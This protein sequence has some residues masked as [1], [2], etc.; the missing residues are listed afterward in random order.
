VNR[1]RPFV[2]AVV[3]LCAASCGSGQYGYS[4]TYE[5][6]EAEEAALAGAEEYDPVMAKRQP[7]VWRTKTV[8]L[9]GIVSKREEKGT[10]KAYLTLSVRTLEARNAC[11]TSV[12]DSCRTTVSDHE[13]D[14]IHAAIAITSPDDQ[15]GSI[16]I[17]PG[18]LVRVIGKLGQPDA[19]DGLE[20]MQATYYRH[21]PRGYF[22]TSKAKE[23]LRR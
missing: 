19:A 12:E 7:E 20:V 22:V 4:R 21:W 15:A 11:E 13:H 2:A 9:F 1:A 8:S 3:A 17:G 10:G 16:S 14:R 5:P 23:V 6:H 18:S